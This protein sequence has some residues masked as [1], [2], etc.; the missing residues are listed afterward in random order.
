MRQGDLFARPRRRTG[1]EG[2]ID[3]V[4]CNPPYISSGRLAGDRAALLEH[5]PREAFD[6]GP[7]GLTIHQRVHEGSAA[8]SSSRAAGC[9]SRSALGQERQIKLLFQRARAYEAIGLAPNAA[10]DAARGVRTGA[11]PDASSG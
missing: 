4:V 7:Y 2:T 5:E 1:L 8:A 3:V 10:G 9:C 11:R 6:G